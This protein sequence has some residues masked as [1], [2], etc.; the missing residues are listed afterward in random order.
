MLLKFKTV[1]SVVN[2]VALSMLAIS[3]AAGTV[4]P[5]GVHDMICIPTAKLAVEEHVI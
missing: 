2:E 4:G 5:A 1:L 3:V